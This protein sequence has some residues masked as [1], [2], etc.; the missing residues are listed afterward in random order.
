MAVKSFT[1]L[2]GIIP[3]GL[4]PVKR[5]AKQAKMLARQTVKQKKVQRP[6]IV[7]PRVQPT[8]TVTPRLRT[9]TTSTNVNTAM[10]NVGGGTGK[11]AIYRANRLKKY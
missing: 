7:L 9:P 2:S 10:S 4:D 6:A 8:Q 11:P 5:A 3:P 1:T